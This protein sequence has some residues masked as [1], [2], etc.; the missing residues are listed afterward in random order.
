MLLEKLGVRSLDKRVS[1]VELAFGAP[2]V[3]VVF[4]KAAHVPQDRELGEFG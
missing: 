2:D 4:D 1:R 3:H